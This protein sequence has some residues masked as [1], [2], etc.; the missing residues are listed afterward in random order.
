M[1]LRVVLVQVMELLVP[2]REVLQREHL[3]A[4]LD[5]NLVEAHPSYP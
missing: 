3:Q 5:R 4:R 1:P 2:W